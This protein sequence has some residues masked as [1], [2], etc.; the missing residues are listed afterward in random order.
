MEDFYKVSQ[1]VERI[2]NYSSFTKGDCHLLNGNCYRQ[3]IGFFSIKVSIF[4]IGIFKEGGSFR[5]SLQ[6]FVESF[7]YP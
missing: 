4:G 2:K 5:W 3:T 7:E 6:L 1:I